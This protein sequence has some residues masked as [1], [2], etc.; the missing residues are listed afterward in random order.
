M[1]RT[2]IE[3]PLAGDFA[4]N[5]R[6]A[7]LCAIDC[8]RRGESPY[9]SH[10]FFTQFLNDASPEDRALGMRAAL[11]WYDVADLAAVYRDLGIS[12]GMSAGLER[13]RTN[14]IPIEYRNLPPDLYA[15]L[16]IGQGESIRPTEGVL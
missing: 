3:S 1:K 4:R 2:V 6:Y 12:G 13:H 10:L 7:R 5:L 15:E 14:G 8:V 16:Q 11:A 9:A